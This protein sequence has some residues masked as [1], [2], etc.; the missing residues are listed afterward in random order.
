LKL[1]IPTFVR[2]NLAISKRQVVV[3]RRFSRDEGPPLVL[4]E[5]GPYVVRVC[6][7]NPVY[8]FVQSSAIQSLKSSGRCKLKDCIG[9]CDTARQ[10]GVTLPAP[11]N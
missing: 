3:A 5:R 8:I 6:C 1:S 11:S 10:A 2:H 7:T 9:W 4:V